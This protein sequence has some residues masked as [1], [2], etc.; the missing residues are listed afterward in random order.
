[1]IKPFAQFHEERVQSIRSAEKTLYCIYDRFSP[2]T[3]TDGRF[4]KTLATLAGRSPHRVYISPAFDN[5]KN[6]LMHEEKVQTLRKMFPQHGRQIVENK[7]NINDLVRSAVSEGFEKIVIL[8]DPSKVS[9]YER[10]LQTHAIVES[11]DYN[12]EIQPFE[13]YNSIEE[14][15]KTRQHAVSGDYDSFSLA[16]N[17]NLSGS[18]KTALFESI[19]EK[20]GITEKPEQNLESISA[21]RDLYAEGKIFQKDSICEDSD[22]NELKIIANGPNFVTT[23]NVETGEQKKYWLD[24]IKPL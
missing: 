22:G 17:S 24:A 5:T 2:P 20:M 4:L 10:T 23:E 15:A 8:C 14:S 6:P 7:T 21:V 13:D 11:Y 12:V 16:F 9:G 18:E 1:M 19:R 3:V